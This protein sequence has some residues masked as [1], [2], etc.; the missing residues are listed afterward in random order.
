M[1]AIIVSPQAGARVQIN[2][3]GV[4]ESKVEG[5]LGPYH[6]ID[7]L[8]RGG[9]GVVYRAQH[10]AT[11]AMVALKTVSAIDGLHLGALRSEIRTLARLHHVGVV[12]ILDEGLSAETPWFAME[13]LEGQLLSR[14]IDSLWGREPGGE[15]S[16]L[17]PRG[18]ER[19]ASG[20][21]QPVH[22]IAVSRRRSAIPPD[23]L[24][25]VIRIV[26]Q[27]CEALVYVHDQ[28]IVHRDLKPSN[29]FLRAVDGGPVLFDFG[30]VSRHQATSGRE[31]V[32]AGIGAR[33]GTRAYMAPEQLQREQVDARTDL[34]ALGCLLFEWLTGHVPADEEK[35]LRALAPEISTSV[36]RPS[37]LVA[38]IPAWLDD[39]VQGL[40]ARRPQDRIG[41]AADVLELL[42]VHDSSAGGDGGGKSRSGTPARAYLY[43]PRLAGRT[44]EIARVWSRIEATVPGDRRAAIY[45]GGE[46]GCGKTML[47]N[48]V[49][50]Q[51]ALVGMAVVA[52]ECRP[53]VG[54]STTVDPRD[55]P[56]HPFRPFL[57]T[58][59]DHCRSGGPAVAKRIL[60]PWA[61]LLARHEP[62][63]ENVPGQEQM[64]DSPP[65]NG[66]A[67]RDRLLGALR[68][69][70]L[71]FAA[72][73]PLL[74]IL[75][76]LQ[77]ADELSLIF[78]R[79]LT[80]EMVARVP[81][82]VLGTFRSDELS[83][84]LKAIVE[85]PS[86]ACVMLSRLDAGAVSSMV[87]DMLGMS[88]APPALVAF[89]VRVS[90][91]NPFFVAEYLR[92]AAAE[93][94]LIRDSGRWRLASFGDG[95]ES[96]YDRL[97]LPRSISGLVI[98]RLAGLS[99]AARGLALQAAVFG[100]SGEV[101]VLA[102]MGD[103]LPEQLAEPIAE[104]VA[105]QVL[106]VTAGRYSFVH[107][108]IREA[109]FEN[110]P[111]AD[112]PAIRLRAAQAL[113]RLS[114]DPDPFQLASLYR[115]AG[116][117]DKAYQYAHLAA[118]RALEAGAFR[119]AR[120][121]L[122][123]A[124]AIAEA[125]SGALPELDRR[126][127]GHL[128]RLLGEAL[129]IS[130][131]LR[132]G[133]DMLHRA[134]EELDLPVPARSPAGW[135]ALTLRE[136][137]H[138]ALAAG[139]LRRWLRVTDEK[140]RA[141]WIAGSDLHRHVSMAYLF[142]VRPLEC[143]GAIFLSGRLAEEAEAQ[144]PSA[145]A[146]SFTAGV[147]GLLGLRRLQARLFAAARAAAEATQEVLPLLWQAG[148]EAI[149]YRY[150]NADWT[151][152][153]RCTTP[154]LA[155]ADENHLIYDRHPVE[156]AV[157]MA[158]FEQGKLTEAAARFE[159]IYLRAESLGHQQ[160]I[161]SARGAGVLC[162]LYAGRFQRI[163][164]ASASMAALHPDERNVDLFV[165]LTCLAAAK[166]RLGDSAGAN[167]VAGRAW[168]LV[169]AGA[170]LEGRPLAVRVLYDLADVLAVLWQEASVRRDPSGP[171]A[172]KAAGAGRK[173]V[174]FAR[175][176][177]YVQPGAI[178][179]EARLRGV[180]GQADDCKK[181][182][183]QA[184]DLAVTLDMPPFEAFA[185][186][187]LARLPDLPDDERLA[188]VERAVELFERMG[189]AWHLDHAS[190]LARHLVGPQT[191]NF[192]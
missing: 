61:K 107:D 82:V 91:G 66:E 106:D 96:A 143:M 5:R 126:A 109:A 73:R 164:D 24:G 167:D 15:A 182:L 67:A 10:G 3:S 184:R 78:L 162:D 175:R 122:Q 63:L 129:I 52:G 144:A 149:F 84:E 165:V 39:L 59:A 46:S 114:A 171:L 74:L 11:G 1:I 151:G 40:L 128:R 137:L 89:L 47:V 62:A 19:A 9:M 121:H 142:L 188:N 27:L 28:G 156:F 93:G 80:V 100:R 113:E 64:P 20:H 49:A 138:W 189:Y 26:R 23:Q 55:A 119:D 103:L 14:R 133:I 150:A 56:L 12:Q 145:A 168:A 134:C 102:G 130:G 118:T 87:A 131:D 32:E 70:L 92:A 95:S 72:E 17:V 127:R 112:R 29:V 79:S 176:Y 86:A 104:L 161:V 124:L 76:D 53:I 135:L 177:R 85:T 101:A 21:W 174:R 157:G 16:T 97:R 25:E 154:A 4:G 155:R 170:Q 13:L 141:V 183:L 173:L 192:V 169:E 8:G 186:F 187:E 140:K 34:Y 58:V 111:E 153:E 99:D 54:E 108:K 31:R 132:P 166:L 88:Q 7:V 110:V 6:L 42:A 180:R 65:L 136:A 35:F 117:A 147:C 36:T 77:W 83:P 190:T 158:K 71:A 2:P 116:R 98:R 38:G 44:A 125:Q 90:E 105:R 139:W 45:V 81:L 178:L 152:L 37:D 146:R 30:L 50:R 185:R 181:L 51:A 160:Y 68:D 22:S 18:P 75:D 123:T 33:A 159:R 120:V 94:V 148:A 57:H 41:Y 115:S 43:R 69:I 191:R 163:V 172:K 48:D 179:L 60:G